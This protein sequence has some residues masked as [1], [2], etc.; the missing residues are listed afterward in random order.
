MR[1]YLAPMQYILAPAQ[2]PTQALFFHWSIAASVVIGQLLWDG[3]FSEAARRV[4]YF[5]HVLLY[6]NHC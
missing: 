4:F 5:E 6:W 1:V 3:V 2:A